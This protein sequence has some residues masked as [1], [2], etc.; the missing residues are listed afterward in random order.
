M[1]CELR[2][3]DW[4]VRVLRALWSSR[5]R[6]FCSRGL[7]W[8][9]SPAVW[10][11]QLHLVM[12]YHILGWEKFLSLLGSWD[13]SRECCSKAK[14]FFLNASVLLK[15]IYLC[16][17]VG[18]L[19]ELWSPFREMSATFLNLKYEIQM[20]SEAAHTAEARG[21]ICSKKKNKLKWGLFGTCGAANKTK[22]LVKYRV[23]FLRGWW[24]QLV[25]WICCSD[26]E[27]CNQLGVWSFNWIC[28]W[29]WILKMHFLSSFWN[30][31]WKQSW[32]WSNKKY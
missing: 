19:W 28:A 22:D 16:A 13:I 30:R 10:N 4:N 3:F 7:F 6:D 27:G 5:R 2:E 1:S 18:M 8:Q 15:S 23:C 20:Q 17:R 14:V 9:R 25:P 21:I 32:H 29:Q 24:A 26:R 31:K 12:S 11:L